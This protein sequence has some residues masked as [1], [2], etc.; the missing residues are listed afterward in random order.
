MNISIS[1]KQGRAPVTVIH[2][3][4]KLDSNSFQRLIDEGKKL[5]AEGA[6]CL[7]VD[8][9]KLAYISSAGIVSL[10]SIAK[11]FRGETVLDTEAGWN[12]IRAVEKDRA[13]GMKQQVKLFNV[14]AEVRN[15][16]DVVGFS[17]FF[18]MYSD[19]DQAV[20]SF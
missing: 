13:D 9:T 15:V 8:M 2:L 11:L 3:D 5:Y 16:L 19:L 18:E 4:G 14:P 20:A 1:Q 7:I 12:A 10:H 6:R 17:S